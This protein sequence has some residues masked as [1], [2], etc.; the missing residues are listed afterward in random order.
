MSYLSCTWLGSGY[1]PAAKKVDNPTFHEVQ[2]STPNKNVEWLRAAIGRYQHRLKE[3]MASGKVV[4]L[5]GAAGS[6]RTGVETA[7]F[8]HCVGL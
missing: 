6:L 2:K 5:A 3:M 8:Y 7:T 4:K 1:E